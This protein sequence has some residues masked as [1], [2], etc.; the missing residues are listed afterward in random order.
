[1]ARH[2]K[3]HE[4]SRQEESEPQAK[5]QAIYINNSQHK[6]ENEQVSTQIASARIRM[7]VYL[8]QLESII[9]HAA[10]GSPEASQQLDVERS[11]S[12]C[13]NEACFELLRRRGWGTAA[14]QHDAT[15]FYALTSLQRSSLFRSEGPSDNNWFNL[16]AQLRTLILA[17]I[18][19]VPAL[20][21]MPSFVATKVAVLLAL[22]VRE[23]YPTTWSSPFQDMSNSLSIQIGTNVTAD[24]IHANNLGISMYLRF[25]DAISD[26]IVYPSTDA[27]QDERSSAPM[28][29]ATAQHISHRRES[30]KDVLR[31]FLINQG[32]NELVQAS[33][34]LEQT[35]AAQIMG[36][37]FQAISSNLDE[38]NAEKL[39]TAGRAA[40]TLT[41]YLSWVDIQLATNESLVKCLLFCLGLA[42][43]GNV[44]M[45]GANDDDDAIDDED[46]DTKPGTTLS[47]ECAN[48]LR[49]IVT[50]GMDEKKKEEL[51][52]NL[53]VIDALCSLTGLTGDRVQLDIT[54]S[55]RTQID[56]VI[57]AAE[58]INAIGLEVLTCWEIDCAQ[59]GS[60]SQ[61]IMLFVTQS[62]ELT[63]TCLNYDDV[64]VSGAVVEIISRVLV[65]IEKHQAYW[66]NI[67]G[68]NGETFC[69]KLIQ[70]LLT[71]LHERM[72][73]PA[74][75]EFDYEDDIEAEE[76]MYRTQLRKLYQRIVRFKHQLVLEFMRQ[77]FSALPQ[78]LA[79]AATQDVEVALR[80]VHHYGEGRR[81]A[82]GANSALKD[83]P[84]REIIM[85]LHLSNV[86]S[87]QHREVLLLYYDLSVRYAKI[88][89]EMP[90]LL[91]NLMGALSGSQGLQHSHPRVRSRC[92]YLLLRM[93]K[94]AGGKAMRSYVEVVV[95]GI[96]G[97][98][99]PSEE[100]TVLPIEPNDALYLFETTG[101]LLGSTGLD[102]DLQQRC[103]TGVLTPH[104]QSIEQILQSPDL[105]RDV[106][107]YAEQ[108]AMSISAIAQLSKGW[109]GHPPPGV[110]N[111]LS[112]STDISLKVLL[113]LSA[114]PIV[115]NRTAVLLQRMILSLGQGIL[116]KIPD[117]FQALLSNCTLE[118]DVLDISQLFNQL[119]IKFKENAVPAIDSSLLPFLQKVLALQLSETS[120]VPSGNSVAPPPHVVTE[121]LSVRKQAFSTLQ[122]IA[123]HNASAVLYSENNVGS[124]TDILRLMNDG[125]TVVPEPVMKK[126]CTM[127]FGELAR[128]WAQEGCPAPVHV[129]NGFFDFIY[130]VFVPGM[131][132]CVLDSSF[133]VKDANQ[134]RVLAE[135][136]VVLWLLKQSYRGNAEFNSRMTELVRSGKLNLTGSAANAC[137]DLIANGFQNASSEKE[138]D[139]CLKAWKEGKVQ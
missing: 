119:C 108:L 19:H 114:S 83:P 113:A 136:G 10:A 43:P 64:D 121:Q 139:L 9:Q 60:P 30:V 112:A 26:E 50:R 48:C 67:Y 65:S 101:I 133:N 16:R 29:A 89:K 82:P 118:D 95:Q 137:L 104:V 116:P 86:S 80:F 41:R 70:R 115:R 39:E 18:A 62:L 20:Q 135:F 31:G 132:H 28:S 17:T 75:F 40:M 22:L 87:H 98:L 129:R 73:Y 106:D 123:T 15:T 130:E 68:S 12:N 32:N 51:L 45:D 61:A 2:L 94:S 3:R 131:L 69:N 99:F 84:F 74:D 42:A 25:L 44:R 27:D 49:E 102:D 55:G 71:I 11:R 34:P 59:K 57:A 92:C 105:H 52:I 107:T 1:M 54:N 35:D 66:N 109:Q 13:W 97:L 124:I 85:A 100:T 78:S 58:L 120:V 47:V 8:T 24:T 125:A 37:L 134:Y 88:L 79:A 91:S 122:H 96:Q 103:A 21:S 36:S 81:P 126:T 76:E 90:D 7:E 93:V 77:C 117:F 128:A 33:K 4:G 138:M 14:A 5:H 53:G 23:D 46:D 110:Q 72:K 38:A 127:F 56:A 63:L 111:V 6:G